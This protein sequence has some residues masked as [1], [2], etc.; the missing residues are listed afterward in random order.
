MKMYLFRTEARISPRHKNKY[1]IA[2]NY[3]P[4]HIYIK[5]KT[6]N[7]ALKEYINEINESVYSDVYVS[8]SAIQHKDKIYI[9]GVNGVPEQVGYK[10][11]ART[12][13]DDKRV[14]LELWADV[15]EL[16]NPFIQ[17]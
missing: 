17:A 3:V 2:E 14:Y 5:A 16:K 13:I 7:N 11:T 6:I 15:L 12:N 1:W 8:K 10:I 9:D 4:K